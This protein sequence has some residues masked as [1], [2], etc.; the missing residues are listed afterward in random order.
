[1]FGRIWDRDK[2]LAQQTG[3]VAVEK[4][5]NIA[6]LIVDHSNVFRSLKKNVGERATRD[7]RF[8]FDSSHWLPAF[9][10]D[11]Q[12]RLMV[13]A[14]PQEKHMSLIVQK[15]EVLLAGSLALAPA[16]TERDEVIEVRGIVLPRTV[17][18]LHTT[19]AWLSEA[20]VRGEYLYLRLDDCIRSLLIARL[21]ELAVLA[22]I[23]D[24]FVKC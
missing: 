24:E 9:H 8:Q 5:K 4:H 15:K 13:K 12:A 22:P 18:W 7:E 19:R 11:Y 20:F 21:E 16:L 23:S 2:F 6:R 14:V 3:C 1:V 17:C 10:L